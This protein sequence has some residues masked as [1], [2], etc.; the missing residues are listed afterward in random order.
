M[1]PEA[2][3]PGHCPKIQG[4]CSGGVAGNTQAGGMSCPVL[5]MII[6]RGHGY[7][8][9]LMIIMIILMISLMIS[10]W[11]YYGDIISDIIIDGIWMDMV[12]SSPWDNHQ[13]SPSRDL[14]NSIHQH[15]GRF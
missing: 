11:I 7:G 6:H 1:I 12:H 5:G 8:T 3:R 10:L 13:T 15:M 14:F 2:T 9:L 4:R